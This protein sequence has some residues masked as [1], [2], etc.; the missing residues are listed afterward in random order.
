MSKPKHVIKTECAVYVRHAWKSYKKPYYVL[1]DLNMTMMKGTI[2]ALLGASGCGKT[3]LLSC[4]VG[5]RSL[6]LGDVWVLGGRPGSRGSGVPGNRVGYMPQELALYGEFSINETMLYFG[7]IYG[8][9]T[10]QIK[11]KVTFLVQLLDLPPA[12]R[13]VKNLSGGQQRRVSLAVAVMHEPELL[14]LDE[15][16]VGVDPILRANIW[17]YMV[18]ETKEKK[19]SIIITTHYIEEARQAQTVSFICV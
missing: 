10:K 4:I 13:L 14:I 6:D 18:R 16:T 8:L 5:I 15:P 12:K 11:E 3:S 17:N 1:C 2:Y 7:W 9:K 19:I